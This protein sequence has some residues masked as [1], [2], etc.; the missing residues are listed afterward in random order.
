ME[1]GIGG[2]GLSRSEYPGE[3]SSLG[4]KRISVLEEVIAPMS[5][6]KLL[7]LRRE[8]RRTVKVSR[9][10]T[11]R[12]CLDNRSCRLSPRR[13]GHPSLCRQRQSGLSRESSDGSRYPRSAQ[14]PWPPC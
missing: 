6:W 2:A 9:R 8:L 10:F 13:G 12:R 4:A 3:F 11:P 14:M 1:A 5:L 7:R